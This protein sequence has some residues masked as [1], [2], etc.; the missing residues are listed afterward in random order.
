MPAG[1]GRDR[2][3]GVFWDDCGACRRSGGHEGG[4]VKCGGDDGG[5]LWRAES[6]KQGAM[7]GAV[8][9]GLGAA[10]FGE[11]PSTKER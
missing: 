4:R 9:F 7:E 5:E 3:G 8:I 11:T 2:H 6:D 1:C 10:L